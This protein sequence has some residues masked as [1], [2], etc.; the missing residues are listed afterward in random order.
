MR[1]WHN[2][3]KQRGFTIVEISIVIL[4][5]GI[6]AMIVLVSYGKLQQ[7]SI[8]TQIASNVSLYQ[9]LLTTYKANNGKYPVTG[10]STCLGTEYTGDKCWL[11]NVSENTAFMADLETLAGKKLPSSDNGV[12]LKG[13]MFT[14]ASAGNKLDGVN[15][16]FLAY[17]VSGD[18][19]VPCPV[20]PVATFQS[21]QLFTSARPTNDQSVGPNSGGDIQ[22]WIAL[23]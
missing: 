9:K 5:I 21:G 23:P 3:G 2:T 10:T 7:R 20:G 6:L 8:N 16:N 13:I 12:Y 15:T 14:P 19:S 1:R 18:T 22:C 17:I 4:V 11:A